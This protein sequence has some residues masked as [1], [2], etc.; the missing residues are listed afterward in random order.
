VSP[1]DANLLIHSVDAGTKLGHGFTVN[2]DSARNDQLLAFAA[3]ADARGSEN[4]L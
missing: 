3:T 4:F 2:L 1:V